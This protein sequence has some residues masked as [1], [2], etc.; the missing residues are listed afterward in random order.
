MDD[1]TAID[2]R[3]IEGLVVDLGSFATDARG[4]C[5]GALQ[6]AVS[7]LIAQLHFVGLVVHMGSFLARLHLIGLLYAV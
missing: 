4:L 3:L 6:T 7:T 1:F 5:L 2:C